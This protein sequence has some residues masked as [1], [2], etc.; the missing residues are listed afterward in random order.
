MLKLALAL[1]LGFSVPAAAV[2]ACLVLNLMEIRATLR[3]PGVVVPVH[4]KTTQDHA[5]LCAFARLSEAGS[6]EE[7][8][9]RFQT[10]APLVL[11]VGVVDNAG[12][13]GFDFIKAEPG[14]ADT[15][16]P[17]VG[18]R[19]ILR[20]A[21]KTEKLFVASGQTFLVLGIGGETIAGKRE[22]DLLELAREAVGTNFDGLMLT[23]YKIAEQALANDRETFEADPKNF[24]VFLMAIKRYDE[25]R[26]Y[27]LRAEAANPYDAE[28]LYEQGVIDLQLT[29]QPRMR[30]RASLG[31]PPSQPLTGS[32]CTELRAA[33]LEKVEEGIVALSKVLK[34]HPDADAA[35]FNL[36][37]LYRERADYQCGDAEARAADLKAA[38]DWSEKF[39]TTNKANRG[40]KISGSVLSFTMSPLQL[41]PPPPPPLPTN[42]QPGSQIGGAMGSII[43]STL[44]VAPGSATP[45]RVNMAGF[46]TEGRLLTRVQPVYP[47][48][49][50]QARIQGTVV[51]KAI[52]SREGSIENL[53]VVSG[54]P[55]LVPAALDAVKQWKYRPYFFN[56]EPVEVDTEI[57]VNF[58]L[59]S[60][61]PPA[62]S[63]NAPSGSLPDGVVGS[64]VSSPPANS[65]QLGVPLHAQMPSNSPSSKKS[66]L[67]Q[68]VAPEEMWNRVRQCV[69][70]ANALVPHD[71]YT[72]GTVEIGFVISPEGNVGDY[73]FREGGDNSL[74]TLAIHAI[75]QWRFA[76][77]V[78]QDA[79]T[80]SRVRALVRFNADGTTSVDLARAFAKDDF[81][82][83]GTKTPDS[84]QPANSTSIAVPRP[85]GAPQCGSETPW[86]SIREVN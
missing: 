71:S 60:S 17:G 30:V 18:D 6:E 3:G 5:S 68:N 82:D 51:L 85:P 20:R 7:N 33:N 58:A 61:V 63:T 34:L 73:R 9:K 16:V 72:A 1:I 26:T 22:Q 40:T 50:R 70:P 64:A 25:A 12:I 77:N 76:P 32:A 84:S 2:D 44:L 65:A 11:S 43:G 13:R 29:H 28:V 59:S 37:L 39:T 4:P 35:M 31:L 45:P 55:F 54:H 8:L 15:E 53:T 36:G 74:R 81:G 21:A 27:N 46:V 49:A 78:V 79:T 47:P 62:T 66:N 19:A 67:I 80:W 14:T 23:K 83:P 86:I 69:F 75:R 57:S 24:A 10:E 42:A 48:L 56:D 52:I 41:P 38:D